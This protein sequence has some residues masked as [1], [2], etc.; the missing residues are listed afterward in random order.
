[1]EKAV[2]PIRDLTLAEIN[3]VGGGDV[4]DS[5]ATGGA[6]GTVAGVVAAGSTESVLAYGAAGGV[7]GAAVGAAYGI[8]YAVGSGVNW[9]YG[10]VSSYFGGSG[11]LGGDLYDCTHS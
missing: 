5:A 3:A 6:V 9:V 8:G 1:M 4:A 10:E 2:N 11:S 7:A